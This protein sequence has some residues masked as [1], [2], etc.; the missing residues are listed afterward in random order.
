VKTRSMMIV[1]SMLL[2]AVPTMSGA[3]PGPS[4]M[5]AEFDVEGMHCGGCSSTIKGTLEAIDGVSNATADHEAGS[6]SATFQTRKVKAED[7][8]AAIEKLGYTVTDVRTRPKE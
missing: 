8:K 3:A 1:V 6:A 4:E 2:L 5:I 7:L